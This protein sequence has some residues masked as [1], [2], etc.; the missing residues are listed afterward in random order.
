VNGLRRQQADIFKYCRFPLT[1]IKQ[2][3]DLVAEKAVNLIIN[4][5]RS[6]GSQEIKK[7]L[8]TLAPILVDRGSTD[9]C[10]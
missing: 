8:H 2:P 6:Y 10:S 5:D 7:N 1:V 9:K 4:P 3:N